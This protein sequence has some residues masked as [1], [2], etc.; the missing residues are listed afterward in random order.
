ME[1]LIK[2]S[3]GKTARIKFISTIDEKCQVTAK[4]ITC[5]EN[6]VIIG[7]NGS[8]EIPVRFTKIKEF[9]LI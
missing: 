4:I 1:E 7:I 9:K 8:M 2:N 3:I 5:S 6:Y